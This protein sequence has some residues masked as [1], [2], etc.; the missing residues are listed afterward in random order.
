MCPDCW[1]FCWF[2]QGKG[3]LN[4]YWLVGHRNYS[5]QNDSLVCN[6]NPNMARKKKMAAGSEVSVG[7][8]SINITKT[9]SITE[10]LYFVKLLSFTKYLSRY[11]M[12]IY[13]F[14]LPNTRTFS[15]RWRCRAWVTTPP[16]RRCPS[17]PQRTPGPPR[18]LGPTDPVWAWRPR[19]SRTAAATAPWA[20]WSGGCRAAM[21]AP[22]P[23]TGQTWPADWFTGTGDAVTM[24][25]DVKQ[26]DCVVVVI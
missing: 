8:V 14:Y 9:L 24:A 20:P 21:T 26:W 4:T 18:C 3:K 17:P 1:R 13:M 6:W 11:C 5:V 23:A 10:L 2:C 7:N 25:T 12:F 19:W 22:C 16:P 15:R